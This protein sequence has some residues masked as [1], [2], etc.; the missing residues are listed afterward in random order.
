MA[1]VTED[2]FEQLNICFTNYVNDEKNF[3]SIKYDLANRV[4]IVITYFCT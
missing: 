1:L 3:L 2:Y 4:I